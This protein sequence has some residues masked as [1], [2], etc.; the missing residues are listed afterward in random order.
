MSE[1]APP[2]TLL[3]G[4]NVTLRIRQRRVDAL[5]A[6]D[7]NAKTH[8]PDQIALIERSIREYG[9]TVPV[10]VDE[11][12]VLIAGHARVEAARNLGIATVP[13]I[14]LDHLT[15]DQARAYRLADN[16]LTEIGGWDTELLRAELEA[17]DAVDFDL[18]LTGFTREDFG[19]LAP[20]NTG[21][22]EEETPEPPD[23]PRTQAGD[24]WVLG[25]HR[26]ICGDSTDAAVVARVLAGEAPALM[27]TDPPF[28]V[29]FDGAWRE[30]A[31]AEGRLR[32]TSAVRVQY[33][34]AADDTEIDWLA[35]WQSSPSQ[36]A[37]IWQAHVGVVPT[38][39]ILT[40]LDWQLRNLIVWHKSNPVISRGQYAN[41]VEFCWYAVRKGATSEWIGPPSVTNL[42]HVGWD[43]GTRHAAQ[44]PVELIERAITYHRGDVYEPFAGSGTAFIAAERQRRRCFGVELSPAFCDVIVERW[45]QYTGRE[46]ERESQ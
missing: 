19:A 43:D 13:T 44:K 2:D 23:E 24:V 18:D 20:P 14:R 3:A 8:P 26:L 12:D 6:Y 31:V 29:G 35:A 11:N 40:S 7:A 46:A 15:P 38:A 10:L 39:E 25:R 32:W 28:G 4:R 36:I 5:K 41:Q 30:R 45:E 34:E 33:M 21:D 9:W 1:A 16:R 37:Y 27:V 17:L 42:W 22:R